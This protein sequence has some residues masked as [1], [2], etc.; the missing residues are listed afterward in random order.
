MRATIFDTNILRSLSDEQFDRINEREVKLGVRQFA[1]PWTLMELIAHLHSIDDSAYR[2]CRAALRRCAK[3]ALAP[4]MEPPRIVEPA[5]LQVSRTV[6]GEALPWLEEN[7]AA[8]IE[9]SR[10]IA[11]SESGDDLAVFSTEIKSIAQHVEDKERWFTQFFG[12]LRQQFLEAAESHTIG[13]QRLE[14]RAFTGSAEMLRHDARALVT[15]AYHQAGQQPPEPLPSVLIDR[16]LATP[17]H[18]SAAVGLLFERII[19]DSADLEKSN[20]RNLLWDQEVAGNMGQ[21]ID[22]LPVLLVTDDKFFAN[23]AKISGNEAAVCTYEE[24]LCQLGLV[25]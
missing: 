15:R 16:V 25:A 12:D 6:F 4:L 5:E 23:V 9:L 18:S 3:R 13:E 7:F 10:S 11:F 17:Q 1:D 2:P 24:Y 8:F 19:C 21:T 22:G 20:I 14:V